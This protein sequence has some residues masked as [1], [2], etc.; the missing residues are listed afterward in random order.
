MRNSFRLVVPLVLWIPAFLAVVTGIGA[1]AEEGLSLSGRVAVETPKTAV[2]Q[3]K[4]LA[5]VGD[6][7]RLASYNLQDFTDGRG[8]GDLRTPERAQRQARNAAA[9][10]EEI[11]PDLVVIEEVENERALLLLNYEF[12]TPF[13]AAF[14]AR[15]APGDD[16]GQQKHNIALLSR[17]PV[18]GLREL[19]F[20]RLE[21]AGQ[22]PRGVLSFIVELGD[23]H[24]LL[25]YGVH[26]KSNYGEAPKNIARRWYAL[27]IVR[28]D[29]ERI[30][31]KYPEYDWEI[32]IAGDMNV[33]PE[34]TG[35][36]GDKSLEPLKGWLDLWQGRPLAERVSL[37]TRRG[38]PLQEFDP[39]TFDR[40]HAS[41]ELR[42]G[43]WI[44]GLPQV[45][46]KGCDTNNVQALAGE[47]NLHVS[48]H[49]P[50]YVDLAR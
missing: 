47:S 27:D 8:D 32:V 23:R 10:L 16:Q 41:S 3:K 6:R 48:D 43:P 35:F 26:L 28:N 1:R 17:V 19:D 25:L 13:P 15:F 45:L 38:D 9:L 33:D 18:V 11:D 31:S 4:Q 21:G 5:P 14:I 42:R 37:P 50:V 29:A 34:S 40:F 12:K 30:R 44:A 2:Y 24:R 22:P 49:Y 36:A 20:G 7:L 46:Q 39:V